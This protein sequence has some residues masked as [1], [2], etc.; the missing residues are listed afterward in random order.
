MM[1]IIIFTFGSNIEKETLKSLSIGIK[2]HLQAQGRSK[3]TRYVRRI[4]VR[5]ANAPLP[6]EAKKILKIW[7]RNGAHS[8]VYLNKYV[9]KI[10]LSVCRSLSP[11][12][13]AWLLSKYN[14]DIENCMFSLF[15][16][17]SIFSGGSADSICPYVRT[18]MY[19]V[20]GSVLNI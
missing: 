4:L 11:T 20:K 5:G 6:P 9:V 7:L 14:I 19:I 17:S 2:C 3:Y 18:P 10:A 1:I 13:L 15:I 12:C 16:F 8:E